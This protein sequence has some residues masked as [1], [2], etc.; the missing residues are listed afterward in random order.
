M[1]GMKSASG[2]GTPDSLSGDKGY[3][4]L[5]F[6]TAAFV[7][8]LVVSDIASSAKIVDLG[9][10]LFGLPMAFDGGTILFPVSYIFGDILTEVYGYRVS[11]RVIWTG[12][13][14]LA[15]TALTFMALGALPGERA[16][17]GYAGQKAY[18][19]ILG[20]I[21]SGG[22][23]VASLLGYWSGSFAN[24]IVLAKM[25]LLSGGRHLWARTIGSTIVGEFLDTFAFVLI[26]TVAGVFPWEIF[27]SLLLT[28]Y[29]FKCSIEAAMT[30]LTYRLVSILKARE[31]RDAYDRGMDFN[32][33]R[34]DRG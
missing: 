9:F 28:N 24:S 20:G 18:D 17:Q 6:I 22:I 3:R 25:K 34:F 13:I 2:S 26:A 30:P 8:A 29:L 15:A 12:F 23:V 5:D 32:P 27:F 21:A 11:R 14:G 31:R 10:S 1:S 19:S 4:Y 7:G 33:F 16:W